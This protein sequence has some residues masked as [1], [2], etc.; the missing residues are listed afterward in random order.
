MIK[1]SLIALVVVG[2]V[3]YLYYGIGTIDV[4][5]VN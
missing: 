1:A 4:P 5:S 2:V 3:F